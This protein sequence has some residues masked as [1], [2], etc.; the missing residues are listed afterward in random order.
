MLTENFLV[1]TAPQPSIFNPFQ[2]DTTNLD[3]ADMGTLYANNFAW[4]MSIS[5]NL[6]SIFRIFIAL[7]Y[8]DTFISQLFM[9]DVQKSFLVQQ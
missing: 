6:V 4:N 9:I 2:N 3:F 5:I 7:S 1:L 8:N